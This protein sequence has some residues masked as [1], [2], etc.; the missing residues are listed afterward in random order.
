MLYSLRKFS[1]DEVAQQ[2]MKIILFYEKHGEK[3]AKEAFGADR[4]VISR[5]RQRLASQG[6]KLMALVPQSTKPHQTRVP[7]TNIRIINWIKKEI[8]SQLAS[9]LFLPLPLAILLKGI[10]SFTR[11]QIT[12]F[13]TIPILPGLGKQSRRKR[14]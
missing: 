4:K 6:G 1:K 7:T 2:R 14:G 12:R 10:I 13:I 3:A 5:W 9:L 11:N 8:V